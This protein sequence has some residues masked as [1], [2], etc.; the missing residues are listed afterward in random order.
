MAYP[1]QVREG[2]LE[3]VRGGGSARGAARRFGVSLGIV[4]KWCRRAGIP[5]RRD[6]RGGPVRRPETPVERPGPRRSPG[7]RL[8]L[9][10]RAVIEVR[11]RDG[12][13]MREIAR[14][15][16]V[17]HTTVAREVRRHVG[18]DGRYRAGRAQ[19]EADASA[20]R[21]RPRITGP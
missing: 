8:D 1:A 5:L 6:R 19:R 10:R 21:P 17:A 16:G 7:E 14:E 3:F 18:P 4:C 11:L 12:R 2:A 9:A 15:M 13:S 20:R